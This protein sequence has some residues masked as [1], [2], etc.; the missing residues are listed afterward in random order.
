M[1]L[2]P[3]QHL[4]PQMFMSANFNLEN[5]DVFNTVF[6]WTQIEES[7]FTQLPGQKQSSKLLQEKVSYIFVCFNLKSSLHQNALFSV[8]KCSMRQLHMAVPNYKNLVPFLARP[9]TCSTFFI[10]CFSPV[11]LE[12]PSCF[13]DFP[14]AKV[15]ALSIYLSD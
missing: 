6:P 7:K 1:L 3:F 12:T 5:P 11:E 2:S 4:I 14:S 13:L 10:L 8:V 9:F 15:L